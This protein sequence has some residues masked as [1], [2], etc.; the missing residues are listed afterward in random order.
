MHLGTDDIEKVREAYV[1]HGQPLS[2]VSHLQQ[3]VDTPD[4]K[5]VVSPEEA[6]GSAVIFEAA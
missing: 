5:L 2:E 6:C 1:A 4:G 3:M